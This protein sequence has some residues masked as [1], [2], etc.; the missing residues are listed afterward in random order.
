MERNKSQGLG[1]PVVQRLALHLPVQGARMLSLVHKDL[2]AAGWLL[3]PLRP[4]AGAPRQGKHRGE[5]APRLQTEK[6]RTATEARQNQK[7]KNRHKRAVPQWFHL[8]TL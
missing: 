5:E 2:T 1:F 7:D 6:A 4:G 3:K 8:H